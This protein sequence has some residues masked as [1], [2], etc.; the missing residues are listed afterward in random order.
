MISSQL[1]EFHIE[2]FRFVSIFDKASGS[3]RE[4]EIN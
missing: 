1:L 2:N 4:K 3:Q